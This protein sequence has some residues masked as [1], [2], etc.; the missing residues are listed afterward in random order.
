MSVTIKL[1]G[2]QGSDNRDWSF[3]EYDLGKS[4][5]ALPGGWRRI[6]AEI[7][8]PDGSGVYPE[9]DNLDGMQHPEVILVVPK[10]E[11]YP[12]KFSADQAIERFGPPRILPEQPA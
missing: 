2:R 4:G 3:R 1:Y 10:S 11:D 9:G 7:E 5:S 12:E 6:V 8:V